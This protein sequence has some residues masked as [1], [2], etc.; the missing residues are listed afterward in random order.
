[1]SVKEEISIP[2]QSD[3]RDPFTPPDKGWR[4]VIGRYTGQ[5]P[6][7]KFLC[8]GG[9]HGN[10]PSGVHAIER[11]L[12]SLHK[13]QIPFCGEVVGLAGNLQALK[14]DTRY[15]E[16]DMNRMWSDELVE[17]A[18]HPGSVPAP[19]GPGSGAAAEWH[20]VADL[21]QTLRAEIDGLSLE[22]FLL[23]LHTSSADGVPF[24][25][26][27]DT[28]RNRKFSRAFPVPI[29]LGLEEQLDGA[30]LEFL[31]NRGVVTMGLEGGQHREAHSIDRHEA[32]IWIGLYSAG[33][34]PGPIPEQVEQG[35]RILG[36][37]R[38]GLPTVMEILH[39]HGIEPGDQFKMCPGYENFTRV[40]SGEILARDQAGHVV[41]P[42]KG[43]LML[44]LY[45]GKGE[46]GF[47]V[48]RE[49]RPFWL[50]VS[51]ILRH[52]QVDRM[53]P[54]LPGVRRHPSIA[55]ALVINKRVARWYTTQLF[56]LLGFR[57]RRPNEQH[58]VVFRRSFDLSSPDRIDF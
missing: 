21:H 40:E 19:A 38:A 42:M 22:V 57:K 49:I 39:R 5:H 20:E 23:D 43:R 10:E 36:S 15:L 48:A 31:N 9:I 7:P 17:R 51:A 47:F 3:H 52:L 13:R 41:S 14:A 11:V 28:L 45:Q 6:G 58:H 8:I 37:A 53:V 54:I 26:V 27:G 55:G 46:D 35:R 24:A 56:H 12:A 25:C 16:R 30:L 50:K 2:G 18:L 34:F 32:G 44:P 29:L 4:R 1:L 33:C